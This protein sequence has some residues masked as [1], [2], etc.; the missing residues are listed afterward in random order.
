MFTITIVKSHTHEYDKIL[1]LLVTSPTHNFQFPWNSE[2]LNHFQTS[3]K[4]FHI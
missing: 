1:I 4:H 3:V 2:T